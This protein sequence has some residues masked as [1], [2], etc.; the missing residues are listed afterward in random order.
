MPAFLLLVAVPTLT[1]REWIGS[2]V[3]T[4]ASDPS[5]ARAASSLT[6]AQG[7][8]IVDPQ[9]A[10]NG[11]EDPLVEPEGAFSTISAALAVAPSGATVIVRPG[12]YNERVFVRQPVQ[13]LADAGTVVTWKSDKPYEA[14]LTVDLSK[15]VSLPPGDGSSVLIS[16]I[17]VRH[18]SPSIA[19]NYAVYVPPPSVAADRNAKIEFRGCDIVS[20]SGSGV[21]VEGGDV[22]LASSRVSSCKNHGVIYV[23]P[24]ARGAVRGSVVEKC[25]LNGV[26][27]RDGAAPTLSQNRLSSNG[28][29]GAA[30]FDCRGVLEPDNIV[31]GNGKGAISGACDAD[32]GA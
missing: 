5:A 3:A 17:S 26:L 13:L 25:K 14:A 15:E 32:D 4:I 12:E 1:R 7:K 31:S 18:F 24:T 23:G 16:G 20:G 10:A 30:L 29:Y 6:H 27:L 19:Q 11:L 28:Q 8:Y 2:A 9:K 22:T 21:G